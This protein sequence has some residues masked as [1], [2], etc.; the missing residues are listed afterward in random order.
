MRNGSSDLVFAKHHLNNHQP[1]HGNP[2]RQVLWR[3]ASPRLSRWRTCLAPSAGQNCTVPC[4]HD[5]PIPDH[6]QPR[7][8][9]HKTAISRCIPES[10]AQGCRLDV[11]QK[12]FTAA[13]EYSAGIPNLLPRPHSPHSSQIFLLTAHD[14]SGVFALPLRNS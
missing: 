12:T 3:Y 14:D 1:H 2:V 9:S 8:P 10:A 6:I 11:L 7:L 13:T 4:R 5:Y